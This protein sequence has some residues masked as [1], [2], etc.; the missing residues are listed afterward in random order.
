[1]FAEEVISNG[2]AVSPVAP[3]SARFNATMSGASFFVAAAISFLLTPRI[4]RSLGDTSYGVLSIAGEITG[5]YGLMDFGIRAAVGYYVSKLLAENKEADLRPVIRSAFWTLTAIA[6]LVLAAAVPLAWW[7]PTLFNVAGADPAEVTASV[8]VLLAVFA[9]NLPNSIPNA[10]LAGMRR[11]DVG[12]ATGITGAI[13]SALCI[14]IALRFGGGLLQVA[15]AQASGTVLIWILQRYALHRLGYRLHLF[16][17]GRMSSKTGDL[18]RYG[19]ANL[20]LNVAQLFILQMD[21]LVIGSIIGAGAVA[22]YHIGRFLG[23]HLLSLIGALTMTLPPSFTHFISSGDQI[24][25][26]RLYRKASE[27]TGAITSLMAA[28]ILV[29]GSDF[30]RL[31][32]GEKYVTGDWWNRSDT[33]LLLMTIAMYARC[34]GSVSNQYLLGSRQMRFFIKVRVTEAVVNLIAS[35]LLLKTL[36]IA[37]VAL[38]KV[39]VSLSSHFALIIPYALRKIG[40]SRAEYAGM[41]ARWLMIAAATAGTGMLAKLAQDPRNWSLFFAEA[42]AAGAAGALAMWFAV[43]SMEERE[44][45][46]GRVKGT[47]GS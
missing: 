18:F 8:G 4:L 2:S 5:Y 26:K 30:L 41:A 42:G 36:G 34:I 31:W 33:V 24:S 6:A 9:L 27:M 20:T 38:A 13:W 28:G 16:P 10:I 29:F 32:M 25:L 3:A 45:I 37:G 14:L 19:S 47:F 17:F 46:I 40:V 7:F 21:L 44:A 43:L 35:V 12:Y 1:M 23:F 11:F 39:I 22:H 15:L